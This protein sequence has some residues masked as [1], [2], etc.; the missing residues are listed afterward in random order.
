VSLEKIAYWGL[1]SQMSQR[2]TPFPKD[3]LVL[4]LETTG[5]DPV[6]HSTIEI[7]AVLLDRHTL[8]EIRAWSVLIK[9]QE[10]NGFEPRSMQEH[11]RSFQFVDNRGLNAKDAVQQFFDV[12]GT[13]YLLT[14]WNI[15]FD[16][17]FFRELLRRAGLADK[18]TMIDY[19]RVDVW[20]IAQFLK[21]TGWF[22]NDVSSFSCLCEELGLPRSKAHRGLEDA[23]LTARALRR[24]VTIGAQEPAIT[25]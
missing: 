13:D 15:G 16:V 17:E 23:Q 3:L 25:S 6:L 21:S 1:G 14:G 11:G 19:H 10:G 24:L 7:G 22:Q 5:R 12:F 9:Q 4:D 18:F 20:S 2:L 8:E